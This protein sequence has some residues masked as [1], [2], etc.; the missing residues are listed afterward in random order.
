MVHCI[1]GLLFR[2]NWKALAK[3]KF[4]L[5]SNICN[6]CIQN[7]CNLIWIL[8][9]LN[10]FHFISSKGI[11]ARLLTIGWGLF[12]LSVIIGYI[13]GAI[14]ANNLS[15]SNKQNKHKVQKY[16][17]I[18][19]MIRDENFQFMAVRNGSTEWMLQVEIVVF[20]Q[21]ATTKHQTWIHL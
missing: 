11:S 18:S 14:R 9:E 10:H 15:Y 7:K 16:S 5:S 4:K 21:W 2:G 3:S 1:N 6:F 8:S 12:L 17:T 20:V 19:D 13:V